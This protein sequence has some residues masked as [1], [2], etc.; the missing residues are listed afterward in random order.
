[1]R[2]SH[3]PSGDRGGC[4]FS[5]RQRA[6]AETRPQ[7][8]SAS[9]QDLWAPF[10]VVPGQASVK[11]SLEALDYDQAYDRGTFRGL[12]GRSIREVL[13]TIGRYGVIDRRIVGA[14]GWRTGFACLHEQWFSQ[15]G[16][17]LADPDYLANLAANFDYERDH[18]IEPSGRVKSRWCYGAYD[19]MP[20]SYD[21]NGYYEAQWGYLLDSQPCYVMCVAELFDMTGTRHGCGAR[22]MRASAC[23]TTCCA[24]TVMAMGWWK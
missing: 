10:E 21:T 15:M 17:A 1:M 14:N 11:Y 22:R 2:F 12:N 19:A 23:W 20:G 9:R 13:N 8:L 6:E 16:I 7:P 5:D 3:Q 18:A 24:A 4:V